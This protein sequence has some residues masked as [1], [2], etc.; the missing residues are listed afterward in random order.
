MLGLEGL[1]YSGVDT[2]QKQG[3]RSIYTHHPLRN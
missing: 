1:K 2:A 3:G